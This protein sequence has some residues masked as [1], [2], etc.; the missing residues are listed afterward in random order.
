MTVSLSLVTSSLVTTPDYYRDH[1]SGWL[2]VCCAFIIVALVLIFGLFLA[3]LGLHIAAW[4]TL[5]RHRRGGTETD[6]HWPQ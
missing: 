2:F 1:Y 4:P 3:C 6:T 5:T